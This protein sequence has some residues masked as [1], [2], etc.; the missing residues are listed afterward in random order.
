MLLME[1]GLDDGV[2]VGLTAKAEAVLALSL[3]VSLALR[4][5]RDLSVRHRV[6]AMEI[7]LPFDGDLNATL[8]AE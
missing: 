1:V 3:L 7:L 4:V 8:S 6:L 2:L 5:L